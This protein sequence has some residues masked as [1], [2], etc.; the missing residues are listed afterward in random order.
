[1]GEMISIS[2]EEYRSLKGAAE[3]LADLQAYDRAVAQLANGNEELL[4]AEFVKRML[5][6]GSPL[7]VWREFR[8]LTQ[9]A[10]AEASS[11]NRV[12]IVDIESGR[13]SGS[14]ET[15]KKLADALGI[16]LDELI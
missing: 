1:M 14:I 4:P 3:E 7:R 16:T 15:V 6:G 13:K 12:Q 9:T 8:G 11:V 5:S 10:L 2:L